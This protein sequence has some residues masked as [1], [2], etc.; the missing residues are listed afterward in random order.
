[1]FTSRAEHRILLRQ[2][3]A[4][5]RLA[6]IAERFGLLPSKRL[7]TVRQ[8]RHIL[9]NVLSFLRNQ[10]VTP[11][12]INVLLQSKG[13][14]PIVQSQKLWDILQR[15]EISLQD[16]QLMEGASW[17]LPALLQDIRVTVES[18][19]KYYGYEQREQ[20][21][22][23]KIQRLAHITIPAGFNFAALSSLSIEAQQKLCRI[24]PATLA[25]AQRIP[26][27]SPADIAVLL[28]RFGR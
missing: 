19:V 13:S 4:D 9:D 11:D 1:M 27:V 26:G 12:E 21:T 20:Q 16:L 10:S 24:Q 25:Q 2:D 17:H 6:P 22:C 7:A 8:Q 23:E 18:A 3:N 28:V 5:M 14:M 15:P